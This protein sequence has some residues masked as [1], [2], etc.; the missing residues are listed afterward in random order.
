MII[1]QVIGVVAV[2]ALALIGLMVVLTALM[3]KF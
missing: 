2:G 3:E 1:F